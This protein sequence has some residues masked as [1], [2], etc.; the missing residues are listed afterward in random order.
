M[1]INPSELGWSWSCHCALTMAFPVCT[2]LPAS[3]STRLLT[4][5][6]HQA[7]GG[8]LPD[9]H[10]HPF[11]QGQGRGGR[12]GLPGSTHLLPAP[13]AWILC[14]AVGVWLDMC[15]PLRMF[16]A[17]YRLA[18]YKALLPLVHSRCS[19]ILVSAAAGLPSVPEAHPRHHLHPCQVEAGVGWHSHARPGSVHSGQPC[20]TTLPCREE[21]DACCRPVS[22]T[23]QWASC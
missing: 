6:R 21:A 5:G 2:R 19:T 16:K 1:E 7:P 18:A 22:C 14:T 9:L 20:A 10:C 23:Y 8:R 3:S 11:R 13:G 15:V 17:A 4:G 12:T